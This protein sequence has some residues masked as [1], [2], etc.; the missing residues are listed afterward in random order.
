MAD[1]SQDTFSWKALHAILLPVGP[2]Y[3]H[4]R[5]ARRLR[6]NYAHM[7]TERQALG[8]VRSPFGERLARH[9]REDE[10]PLRSGHVVC[11]SAFTQ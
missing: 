11:I 9:L 2:D 10:R 4:Y 1:D 3:F 5:G 8:E 6:D 7:I